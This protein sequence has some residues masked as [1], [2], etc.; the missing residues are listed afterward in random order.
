MDSLLDIEFKDADDID[1][2]NEYY[3]DSLMEELYKI[4]IA[5]LASGGS[6]APL[7]NLDINNID[8][9]D[10]YILGMFL[11]PMTAPREQGEAR[12]FLTATQYYDIY[13]ENLNILNNYNSALNKGYINAYIKLLPRHLEVIYAG[14]NHPLYN[15][16][17][18]GTNN[19]YTKILLILAKIG[20][21]V[22]NSAN[23]VNELA[24]Y[25]LQIENNI[26]NIPQNKGQ[27]NV[28]VFH[29]LPGNIN[30]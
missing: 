20:L 9:P 18:V 26:Q 21:S 1:Q 25:S 11:L 6:Q 3:I 19:S 30:V 23:R 29:P 17:P 8:I 15:I 16:L 4:N 13:I 10:I 7:S 22:I 2:D 24:N 14:P 12:E 5:A 27:Y 28:Q